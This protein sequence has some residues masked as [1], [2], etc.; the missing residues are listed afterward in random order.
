MITLRDKIS[1][2]LS[3]MVLFAASIVMAGLGF[4][5]LGTL[6]LFGLAA[7]GVAMIAA[8]FVAKPE[9]TEADASA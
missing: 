1:S 3:T 2:A 6:A 5:F 9:T 4:A 7:F 8:L